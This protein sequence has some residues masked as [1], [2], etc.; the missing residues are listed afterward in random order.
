MKFPYLFFHNRNFVPI[1]LKTNKVKAWGIKKKKK[2]HFPGVQSDWKGKEVEKS[3]ISCL[4]WG[5][6]SKDG[7]FCS[8]RAKA[9]PS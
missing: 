1:Y 3:P 5:E 4:T 8:I 9:I 6:V 7:P 2:R